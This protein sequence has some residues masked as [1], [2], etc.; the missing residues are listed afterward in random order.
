MIGRRASHLGHVLPASLQRAFLVAAILRA[1]QWV[2]R[3]LYNQCAC[4]GKF[5]EELEDTVE[6]IYERLKDQGILD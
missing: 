5:S 1:F 2:S 4:L 6:E 3:S